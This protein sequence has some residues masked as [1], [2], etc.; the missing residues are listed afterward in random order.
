M[1]EILG[2]ASCTL[3][4]PVYGK[5]ENISI[6]HDKWPYEHFPLTEEVSLKENKWPYE[7]FPPT[8]DTSLK[9]NKPITHTIFTVKMA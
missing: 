6:K 2:Y 7:H 5:S 1:L 9:E 8:E 3:N 4:I